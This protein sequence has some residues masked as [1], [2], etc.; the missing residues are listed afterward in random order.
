M[1]NIFG[2]FDQVVAKI[3]AILLKTNA[4]I[5]IFYHFWAKYMRI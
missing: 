2:D 3:L 5:N 4:M 1:I